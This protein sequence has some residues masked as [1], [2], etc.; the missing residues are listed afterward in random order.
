[1]KRELPLIVRVSIA[2]PTFDPSGVDTEVYCVNTTSQGFTI[3]TKS[4][5]FTT[6]EE[7]NGETATHGSPPESHWLAEGES[8]LIAI[9]KG[10]EWDGHV[11]I[12]VVFQP[13]GNK[14]TFIKSYNL[15]ESKTDYTIEPLGIK[16]RIISPLQNNKFTKK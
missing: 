9:V 15:K 10:W 1:M 5:S 4:E 3:S 12:Q 11:G 14:A 2:Q 13:I 6:I 16:G 7:Q 8:A